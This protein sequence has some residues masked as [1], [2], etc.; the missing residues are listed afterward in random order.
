MSGTSTPEVPTEYTT[1][2]VIGS[3]LPGL[4][5]AS[6]L[7]RRGVSSI[8]VEGLLSQPSDPSRRS[9][10]PDSSDRGERND[11]LRLLQ[12]YAASHELDIRRS[13]FACG[14][15]RT[16]GKSAPALQLDPH[17]GALEARTARVPSISRDSA[18]RWVIRTERGLLVADTVVLTG[19]AQN[20][21]RRLLRSL[22][23]A[24]GQNAV[25]IL[26]A[27][28]LY[29]VGVADLLAPSTREI[30]RQAKVAGNAIASSGRTAVA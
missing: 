11:L 24:A 27:I 14:V 10:L 2:V 13:T 7:S 1:T 28:G 18:Q 12:G 26:N 16:S 19:C 23:I 6:E 8:V 21:M 4:A 15:S 25:A 3:G 29:L 22:G 30:I 9:P 20:Q 5:V 17:S